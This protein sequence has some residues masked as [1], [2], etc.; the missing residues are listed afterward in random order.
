MRKNLRKK[1][2]SSCVLSLHNHNKKNNMSAAKRNGSSN[3]PFDAGVEPVPVDGRVGSSDERTS[4]WYYK[5]VNRPDV[6]PDAYSALAA[7][8]QTSVETMLAVYAVPSLNGPA[9]QSALRLHNRTVDA[10]VGEQQQPEPPLKR[11]TSGVHLQQ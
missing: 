3:V 8:M 10:S 4:A 7:H 9:A 1:F 5:V 2:L 11:Q 6:T